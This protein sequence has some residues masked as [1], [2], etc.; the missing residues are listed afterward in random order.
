MVDLL[1]ELCSTFQSVFFFVALVGGE[2]AS[3][4]CWILLFYLGNAY[5]LSFALPWSV[6]DKP[7]EAF[8]S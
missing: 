6:D 8:L 2:H 4:T 7:Y 3:G 5:V 1:K